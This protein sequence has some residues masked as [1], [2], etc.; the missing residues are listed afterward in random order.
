[1]SSRARAARSMSAGLRPFLLDAHTAERDGLLRRAGL[2]GGRF[3]LE[4]TFPGGERFGAAIEAREEQR[5]VEVRV[6]IVGLRLHGATVLGD[7][8]VDLLLVLRR[9]GE[10]VP[11]LGE[12]RVARN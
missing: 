6:S 11:S 7:S 9:Q 1:M 8:E 5:Q 3:E 10:V 4:E 2:S 12:G